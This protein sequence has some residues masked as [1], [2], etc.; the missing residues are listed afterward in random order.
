MSVSY[1][2]MNVYEDNE[3]IIYRSACD[4]CDKDDDLE[5]VISTDNLEGTINVCMSGDLVFNDDFI[6]Y[7]CNFLVRGFGHFKNIIRRI[8]TAIKLIFTGHLEQS[9]VFTFS[10][11]KHVKDFTDALTTGIETLKLKNK[12]SNTP[13]D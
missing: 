12:S 8:K 13:K 11:E 2:V 7:A 4:C 6:C 1:K 5:L 10:D 3:T 9:Y